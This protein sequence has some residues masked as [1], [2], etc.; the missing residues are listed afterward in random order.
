MEGKHGVWKRC[1]TVIVLSVIVIVVSISLY[2][3][4]VSRGIHRPNNNLKFSIDHGDDIAVSIPV[5][6][7]PDFIIIGVRKGGTK[8][9]ITML[10]SHP[11]VESAKGEVHFFDD[12]DLYE[13]KGMSWYIGRMPL[14]RGEL[15][16]E[17][18]PSYFVNPNVPERIAKSLPQNV[19][20]LLIV[21]D[22]IIRAISDYT[23]LDVKKIRQQKTRLSFESVAFSANGDIVTTNSVIGNSLYDVHY[24]RWL[25][26]FDSK[27]ILVVDGDQLIKNP[28]TELVK[29]EE[30]LRLKPYFTPDKLYYNETKGFYCWK[31]KNN[32]SKCLG[33]A[34]GRNH[35]D[36]SEDTKTKL[37]LFF[38]PHM[39][40]FCKIANLSIS[41]CHKL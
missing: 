23:Q 20:F 16:V 26:Y 7:L 6:K 34:K 29:I 5:R 40:N 19:K 8:A 14:S 4:L 32:Q 15:I 33:S 9:L 37:K 41:L 25:Q 22:P 28:I 12:E 31:G 38:E 21:R 36:I 10:N 18:T 1:I 35:S 11:Q 27:R 17:K 30:Y 3:F 39:Q 2:T 24:Q 13:N